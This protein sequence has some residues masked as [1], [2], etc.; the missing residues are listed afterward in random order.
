MQE[1]GGIASFFSI[2]FILLYEFRHYST[3]VFLWAGILVFFGIPHLL[4]CINPSNIT[5]ILDAASLFSIVFCFSYSIGRF[6]FH[7][8]KNLVID[9][10]S[11][12]NAI[13]N[14]HKRFGEHIINILFYIFVITTISYAG[15]I[16]VFGGS[17]FSISKQLIY[18]LRAGSM[19]F[20]AFHYLWIASMPVTLYYLITRNKIRASIAIC[21][22]LEQGIISFT[23][24][25]LICFFVILVIFYLF[26]KQNVGAKKIL[27]ITIISVISIY[28]MYLLRAFRYYYDFSNF[29]TASFEILN[30]YAM[31]FFTDENGDI[32]LSSFFYQLIGIDNQ[33]E[34][35]GTGATYLRLLLLPIPSEL[36]LGLKPPDIS[37][38]LGYLFGNGGDYAVAYTVTP[39]LFGD[40]Y[41]N[42]GFFGAVMGGF[43]A[44]FAY[45]FDYLS[46]HRRYYMKV[47]FTTAVCCAYMNISRGDVYNAVA[48]VFYTAILYWLLNHILKLCQNNSD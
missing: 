43:W 48:G 2:L 4:V 17:I 5:D 31:S 13:D 32:F 21:C 27:I 18:E 46:N 23:R 7:S 30:Q 22:I 35:L 34:G 25:Y 20:L 28:F 10:K 19:Y 3:A 40:C 38:T 12:F 26:F 36:L 47:L 8:R 15:T 42:F 11:D 1:I 33:F 29:D 16:I 39:T 9:L 24:S 37:I 6:F 44:V 14:K 45:F 41:A